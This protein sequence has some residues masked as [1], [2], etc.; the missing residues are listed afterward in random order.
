MF[1]HLFGLRP[2]LPPSLPL[3][4]AA[5]FRVT[6]SVNIHYLME[7]THTSFLAAPSWTVLSEHNVHCQYISQSRLLTLKN[8]VCW[9]LR[10]RLLAVPQRFLFLLP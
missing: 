5:S 8:T 6:E 1:P 3:P 4:G 2:L 7:K 10:Q 9:T